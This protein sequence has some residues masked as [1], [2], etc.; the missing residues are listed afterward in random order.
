MKS[1]EKTCVVLFL[2]TDLFM[3]V[4][5]KDTLQAKEKRRHKQVVPLLEYAGSKVLDKVEKVE[6][7]LVIITES[8]TSFMS[9]DS[10]DVRDAWFKILQEQFG[11]GM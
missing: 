3:L 8:Q 4:F 7:V 2:F 11:Q 5:Y 9:F 1:Y 6:N 10:V